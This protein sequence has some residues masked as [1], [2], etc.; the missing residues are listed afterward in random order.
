MV[1]ERLHRRKRDCAVASRAQDE[2]EQNEGSDGSADGDD[3][4]EGFPRQ[5]RSVCH[6]RKCRYIL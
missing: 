4:D 2:N 1:S 6:G 5:T 3:D